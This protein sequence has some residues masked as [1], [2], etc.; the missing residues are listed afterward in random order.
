MKGGKTRQGRRRAQ[1]C[2]TRS[3][4]ATRRSACS[5]RPAA[6]PT[7]SGSRRASSTTRST[8]C[9]SALAKYGGVNDADVQFPTGRTGGSFTFTAKTGV[10]PTDAGRRSRARPAPARRTRRSRSTAR[11]SRS[12]STKLPPSPV[13]SVAAALAKYAGTTRQRRQH[14]HRRPHLGPR[15]EPEG[16]EGADHLLLRAR[17]VPRDPVRVEDVGRR[18]RR[19]DPRHHLHGR[20]LRAVPFPG[21]ARDR[22]RVPDH[23][24]FLAVRHRRRVRQGRR[25]PAL[26]DRDR[27]LDVLAR[28]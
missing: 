23:P 25:V 24:R 20:R 1:R 27:P 14:H 15:G 8:S 17:R 16:A 9:R 22:H 21:V 4:S 26:A 6:A 18:D 5:R 19:G 12:R 11:R 28:W 7:R 13:Q 10:K 3:A 2:S